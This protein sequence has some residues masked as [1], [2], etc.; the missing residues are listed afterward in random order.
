MKLATILGLSTMFS[1]TITAPTPTTTTYFDLLAQLG[2]TEN[3]IDFG[4]VADLLPTTTKTLIP[5]VPLPIPT[6]KYRDGVGLIRAI[7][8]I[9]GL[10]NGDVKRYLLFK[11]FLDVLSEKVCDFVINEAFR[12]VD[13]WAF[14]PIQFVEE[15]LGEWTAIGHDT[16]FDMARDDT[17]IAMEMAKAKGLQAISMQTGLCYYC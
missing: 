17:D 14:V 8:G 7:L 13:F 15:L 16:A 5:G 11:W 9:T 6:P 1:M 4:L 2:P 3:T 10:L 12:F